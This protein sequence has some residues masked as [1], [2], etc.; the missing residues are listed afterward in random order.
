LL[1]LAWLVAALGAAA[2]LVLVARGWIGP[3][4]ERVAGPD[5]RREPAAVGGPATGDAVPAGANDVPDARQALQ[6]PDPEA[7]WR[8]HAGDAVRDVSREKIGRSLSPE[9]E[10]RL[11]D[12]MAGVRWAAGE[13]ERE[14]VDPADPVSVAR[15]R[16]RN[17]TILAADAT[18]RELTGLGVAEFLRLLDQEQIEDLAPKR[19]P[20]P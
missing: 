12:A 5:P 1:R 4:A 15:E 14:T 13:G 11:V 6:P 3:G 20:E 10:R 16:E 9:D 17:E 18:F 8:G 2:V 7:A 19:P